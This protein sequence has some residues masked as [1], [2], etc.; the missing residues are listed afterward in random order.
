MHPHREESKDSKCHRLIFP[1]TMKKTPTKPK[2][3]HKLLYADFHDFK[4][5]IQVIWTILSDYKPDPLNSQTVTRFS[6]PTYLKH[7]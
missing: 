1:K 5:N 2:S 6:L 7:Q 4:K 3:K